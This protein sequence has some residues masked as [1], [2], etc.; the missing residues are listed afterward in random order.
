MKQYFL[1]FLKKPLIVKLPLVAIMLISFY[2][3]SIF[4]FGIYQE[5]KISEEIKNFKFEVSEVYFESRFDKRSYLDK[6]LVIKTRTPIS[7]DQFNKMSFTIPQE[8][9]KA[10]LVSD[11]EIKVYFQSQ[12][13]KNIS[14]QIIVSFNGKRIY[15]YGFM[16]SIFDEEDRKNN[17]INE[18]DKF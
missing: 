8:E 7:K 4:L 1:E 15:N 5:N 2:Y 14:T 9:V 16:N 11:K 18:V 13:R 17:P 6:Y 10:E 12:F 3:L